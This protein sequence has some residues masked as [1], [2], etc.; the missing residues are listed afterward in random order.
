[1]NNK[2]Y[3]YSHTYH[4]LN[5]SPWPILTSF[6]LLIIATGLTLWMHFY[7]NGQLLVILGVVLT[8][9]CVICWWRDTIRESTFEGN[10][11]YKVQLGLRY[12][13][14]LFIVSEIMLFVSFLWAFFH[15]SLSPTF[16]LGCCWP[17]SGIR[18]VGFHEIPLLNTMLLLLSGITITWSHH[19]ICIGLRKEFILSLGV[20]VLL[21]FLFTLLQTWEYV[22]SSFNITDSVYGSIFFLL[23]GLH[24]VHIIAGSIFLIVCIIRGLRYHFTTTHHFGFEAAAWYWHFVDVVWLFLFIVVYWW[25]NA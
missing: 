25:G 13:V 7:Q 21:A 12:G 6:S 14:I 15:S 10:H 2:R 3:N 4:L 17:P 20:T 19:A 16:D 8:S 5:S 11:T 1:M 24:G 23:T 9:S 18:I 22:V